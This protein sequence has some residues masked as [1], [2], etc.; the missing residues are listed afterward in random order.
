MHVNSKTTRTVPNLS[1]HT[2]TRGDREG[3]WNVEQAKTG[4]VQRTMTTTG[5]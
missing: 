2:Q 5:K 3:N 1:S 4:S